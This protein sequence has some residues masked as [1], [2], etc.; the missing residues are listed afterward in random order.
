ME[1]RFC[2]RFCVRILTQKLNG[3][4]ESAGGDLLVVLEVYRRLVTLDSTQ[5]PLRTGTAERN[6]ALEC[7][8]GLVAGNAAVLR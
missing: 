8:V 5:R 3:L 6:A 1:E 4:L 7:A 2:I